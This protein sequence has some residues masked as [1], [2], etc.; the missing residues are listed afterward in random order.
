MASTIEL[1]SA[2]KVIDPDYDVVDDQYRFDMLARFGYPIS[3]VSHFLLIFVFHHLNQPVLWK[4]NIISVAAIFVAYYLHRQ[5]RIRTG[6]TILTLETLAYTMLGTLFLG[7]TSGLFMYFLFPA[8]TVFFVPKLSEKVKIVT[9]VATAVL[10]IATFLL[11]ERVGVLAPLDAEITSLFLI[12]N[13]LLGLAGVAVCLLAFSRAIYIAEDRLRSTNH[14]LARFSGAVSEYLDPM[15][16]GSLQDGGDVEPKV[17][18][19]TVFFADLAGS[20]R[21]SRAMSDSAFGTM[22]QEFVGEMQRIIKTRRGY[23]EDISGDGIFGYLGN[24]ESQGPEADAVDAVEMARIMQARLI[25][26]SAEFETRFDLPETLLMRVGI[27]SGEALVGK[28]AGARAIYTAN[29]DI[30]NLGAKLEQ[31]LKELSDAGGI[32]ISAET[33]KLVAGHFVLTP[34]EVAIEGEDMTAYTVS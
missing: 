4:Y 2:S 31:K 17:H 32:L 16:V 24:F 18:F 15:L 26:L 3:A 7:W 5:G 19:V 8:I 22:I 12:N 28:T 34:H 6:Y 29:G 10:V 1:A 23:L 30:V 11:T 33:A 13:L 27:S 21:I 25:E 20:T 14:R 9:V